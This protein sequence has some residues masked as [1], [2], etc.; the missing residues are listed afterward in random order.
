MA[1]AIWGV[2]AIWLIIILGKMAIGQESLTFDASPSPSVTYF[3][4]WGT[5]SGSAQG[6]F[7]L[8]TNRVV[9]LTNGPWGRYFFTVTAL[10]SNQVE[11]FPSNELLATNRPAAPLELRL[12]PAGTNVVYIDGSF[13]GLNWR[14]L[15]VVTNDP[16]LLAMQRQQMF[17]ASNTNLPPLPGS[18]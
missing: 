10:S 14:R 9:A 16:A 7:S 17:R 1:F 5:N 4:K 12:V 2:A 18:P 3:I 8:G 13:N 11:S 15:A 6:G